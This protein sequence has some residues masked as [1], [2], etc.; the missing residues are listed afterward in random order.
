MRKQTKLWGSIVIA[1]VLGGTLYALPQKRRLKV[2]HI[3]FHPGCKNDFE[4]VAREL[5][6]DLTSWMIQDRGQEF[7]GCD[8]PYG[9]NLDLVANEDFIN[10]V[11]VPTTFFTVPHG[12]AIYNIN[13]ERAKRAWE[14]NKDTFY[15]FDT[16]VVSD[17]APLSRIFLQNG[18]EK[19]LIIWVCNRFDYYDLPT[20]DETFPDN[21]YYKLM[22]DATKRKNV[23]FASYTPYE[24]EYAKRKGVDWGDRIIKPIGVKEKYDPP[25]RSSLRKGLKEN[26]LL[27]FPRLKQDQVD[28]VIHE[29]NTRAIRTW[30][31]S[32]NGPEDIKGF[33][34]GIFFPYAYSNLALFENLQRGVIHFVPT[35][36]FLSTL[37]FYR[38]DMTGRLHWSEWYLAEYQK[39][40]MYFNSW[41]DLKYKVDTL[42]SVHLKFTIKQFG[43]H[44]RQE[45]LRRWRELFD[46]ASQLI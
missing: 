11:D 43:Y 46:Q 5:D 18:W 16:V 38:E 2:L 25:I 37:K 27:I 9:P 15:T 3:T 8:A 26:T 4:E 7:W 32:Y 10:Q 29:C 12:N 24:R 34:G 30:H 1:L 45:M 23:F 33:K 28:Q 13:H 31:G 19:P 14:V 40:I 39:L 6:L 22:Y 35:P 42:N 41:D 17:T 21:E 20:R 36:E 44:H